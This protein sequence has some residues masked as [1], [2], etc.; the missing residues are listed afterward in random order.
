[1]GALRKVAATMKGYCKQ[2]VIKSNKH[3]YLTLCD[4][5]IHAF[6]VSLKHAH[7]FHTYLD[8]AKFLVLN[9][10]TLSRIVV[11]KEKAC[12]HCTQCE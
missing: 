12:A 11:V 2:F 1:M 3:L 9:N 10:F 5:G 6:Y 4:N 8:A 7:K